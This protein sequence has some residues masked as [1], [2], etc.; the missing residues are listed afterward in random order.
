MD[1]QTPAN[2]QS[3]GRQGGLSDTQ[4]KGIQQINK[5]N[6]TKGMTPL[7]SQDAIKADPAFGRAKAQF[8]AP[9]TP[10]DNIDMS[11]SALE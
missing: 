2:A 9:A 3:F 4:A 1:S 7:Q 5:N 10:V 6:L 8:N 11:Q